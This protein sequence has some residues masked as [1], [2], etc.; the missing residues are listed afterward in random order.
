[1]VRPGDWE[2]RENGRER[3]ESK[4]GGGKRGMRSWGVVNHPWLTETEGEIG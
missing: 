3:G 1:M 2:G 4:E